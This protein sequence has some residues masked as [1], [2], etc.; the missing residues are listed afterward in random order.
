MR[1][2]KIN[3]FRFYNLIQKAY[4]YL[5]YY[6]S[7]G[8]AFRPIRYVLNLTLRCNLNCKFCYIGL[9]RNLDELSTEEWSNIIDQI[10]KYSLISLLGGEVLLRK[11][12]KILFEKAL[13]KAKVNLVTNGTLID[14]DIIHMS[15]N[16]KLFLM[17]F[18]LDGVGKK[19]DN[20]RGKV[21]TFDKVT[22]NIKKLVKARGNKKYPLIDIKTV[23][24]E[25]NLD[26]IAELYKLSAKLGADFFTISFLKGC[27]L[28]QDPVL[29]E[30][31]DKEFYKEKYP[32]SNYFDI[33]HFER[34]YRNLL[35]LSKQYPVQIRLYPEFS[36]QRGEKELNIIK[37]YFSKGNELSMQEVYNPCLFPWTD[38]CILPDGNVF[39]CLS[40]KTGNV[41]N[42]AIKNIW[43]SNKYLEFRSALKKNR[44]FT[45]CQG[46]CNAKIR[47][48]IKNEV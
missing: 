21:G 26:D 25:D 23:I 17:A 18:S 30:K 27:S 34:V 16:N 36:D 3:C 5:P 12:F 46:C 33:D 7:N 4:C 10:P 38:I 40:Y 20:T 42:S 41:K 48:S 15:V 9:N 31:F 14:D 22:E 11:D 45:S 19:H 35:E 29:R 28:Q 43:N 44:I 1:K 8:K 2:F 32:I 13:K 6:L 47:E 24:L 39:P 37:K